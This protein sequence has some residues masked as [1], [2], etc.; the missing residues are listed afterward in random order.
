MG[1]IQWSMKL[2]AECFKA[3]AGTPAESLAPPESPTCLNALFLE[4]VVK[5]VGPR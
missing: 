4:V 2:L 3:L 5:Q 1:S